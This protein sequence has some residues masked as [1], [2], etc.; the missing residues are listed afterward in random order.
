MS[1]PIT[2][3][4][5]PL[6]WLPFFLQ[7]ADS[8]FPTGAYAHSLGLEESM[9]L[10]VVKNQESLAKFLHTQLLPAEGAQELPYLRFAYE[11]ATAND[12]ATLLALDAEVSAWKIPREIREGSAQLGGRRLLVLHRLSNAPLLAEFL[13]AIRDGK[14]AGHHLVI[15]G[16]QGV[17]QGAPLMATLHLHLYQ[18]L[19]AMCAAAMKLMRIGQETC[20]QVLRRACLEISRVTNDSLLVRRDDAGWFN[21]LLD[22]AAMRHER[23][24]ERLFI[25]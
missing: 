17:V 18:S 10:G 3:E 24:D 6:E 1:I 5:T 2:T 8:Q 4:Q 23:A 19:A 9:R 15:F 13:E 22:I 12:V 21:P 20:Q 25:S 16:M 11:A 14:A 7:A